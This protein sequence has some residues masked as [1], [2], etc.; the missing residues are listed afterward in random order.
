MEYGYL[1]D[2]KKEFP[3]PGDY[4]SLHKSPVK[5][6]SCTIV[7]EYQWRAALVDEY[8][9]PHTMLQSAKYEHS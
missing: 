1:W 5:F 6:V 3:S 7:D 2:V 9:T 8:L 4:E